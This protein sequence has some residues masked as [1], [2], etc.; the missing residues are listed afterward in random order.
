MKRFKYTFLF[1][2]PVA[3]FF[4]ACK[5]V[6]V[7]VKE[8]E[9]V[10]IKDSVYFRDTTVQYQIEKEY[11]RDY[12]GLLD[13]LRLST[14]FSEFESY[15]DTLSNKLS[16]SARNKDKSIPVPVQYKERIVYRDSISYKEKPI[17]IEVE[18]KVRYTPWYAK[19]LTW[20]GGLALLGLL[21][22]FLRAYLR[23]KVAKP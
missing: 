3:V 12:T 4:T 10:H 2:L 11:I 15:I 13:T 7:P 6:Y 22:Y 19:I 5:T 21:I 23:L 20:I 9:Y 8:T 14:N 1:W 16:G 17:P 18:K